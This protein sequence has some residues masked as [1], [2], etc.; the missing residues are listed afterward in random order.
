MGARQKRP[1]EE[2]AR[3]AEMVMMLAAVGEARDGQ[4]PVVV[5]EAVCGLV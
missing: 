3:V 4:L 2:L 1:H 5:E